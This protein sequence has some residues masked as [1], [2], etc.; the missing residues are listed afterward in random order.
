MPPEV[1]P[2]DLGRLA[3]LNGVNGEGEEAHDGFGEP[4]VGKLI[5]AG[6]HDDD[7]DLYEGLG[8]RVRRDGNQEE[9]EKEV[10]H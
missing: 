5:G 6:E 2:S 10:R 1:R 4:P 8:K 7:L 9:I 3:R